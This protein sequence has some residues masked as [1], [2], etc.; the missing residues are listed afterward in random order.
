MSRPPSGSSFHQP[1]YKLPTSTL[2]NP[3]PTDSPSTIRNHDRPQSSVAVAPGGERRRPKRRKL[4]FTSQLCQD[5]STHLLRPL[6]SDGSRNIEWERYQSTLRLKSKWER[7]YEKFKDA[8]LEDQDEIY[9]GRT[10]VRGDEIRIIKDRGTVRRLEGEIKFG[11]LL[12]GEDFDFSRLARDD[13]TPLTITSSSTSSSSPAHTS[14]PSSSTAKATG[15]AP[16][17]SD[18]QIPSLGSD[19]VT[20][21]GGD[22]DGGTQEGLDVDGDGKARASFWG[23][24]DSD[25]DEIGGWGET[26]LILPQFPQDGPR[27]LYRTTISSN[28]FDQDPQQEE[29][30]EEEEASS[31]EEEGFDPDLL[32]FLKAEAKRKE[33]CG[34]EDEEEDE[35]D[36]VVDFGDPFWGDD[37][38]LAPPSP[39]SITTTD[40]D[41]PSNSGGINQLNL[42]PLD[43]SLSDDEIDLISVSSE[44][45]DDELEHTT[46]E[47]RENVE[48]LLRSKDPFTLP[49]DD[50]RGLARLLGFASIR[51]PP[52]NR[53]PRPPLGLALTPS[54]SATPSSQDP[55][56]L[57][58][59]DR[60]IASSK[61]PKFSLGG[62]RLLNPTSSIPTPPPTSSNSEASDS[63]CARKKGMQKVDSKH[64]AQPPPLKA[65]LESKSFKSQDS[66]P[67]VLIEVQGKDH[68]HL[69]PPKTPTSKSLFQLPS[70]KG[71]KGK[72][73]EVSG[74]SPS[75]AA[76]NAA[77]PADSSSSNE[78]SKVVEVTVTTEKGRK[79][80]LSQ[81]SSSDPNKRKGGVTKEEGKKAS[82]LTVVDGPLSVRR[83]RHAKG[84]G[85]S[86]EKRDD[87]EDRLDGTARDR[88]LVEEVVDD[89]ELDL[90][91]IED[92]QK[93]AENLG[94][95]GDGRTRDASSNVFKGPEEVSKISELAGASKERAKVGI[96]PSPSSSKPSS[97]PLKSTPTSGIQPSVSHT[98]PPSEVK[99]DSAKKWNRKIP[100][101]LSRN[102][103][104]SKVAFSP[105]KNQDG[106]EEEEEEEEDF[107]QLSVFFSKSFGY[108]LSTPIK[109]EEGSG[110]EGGEGGETSLEGS[111]GKKGKGCGGDKSVCEKSF[112]MLCGGAS[113][114]SKYGFDKLKVWE[115]Q[116]QEGG[117]SRSRR[118]KKGNVDL[119]E[120]KVER[121][122]GGGAV[123]LES[124][125]VGEGEGHHD[126]PRGG[127][128]LEMGQSD[129]LVGRLGG[130]G[131]PHMVE[132][133]GDIFGSRLIKT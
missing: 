126:L 46:E 37:G 92:S 7:I 103:N 15:L 62:P 91:L 17:R 3:A 24:V 94:Q 115:E 29:E 58:A 42:Q 54:R 16:S 69:P 118:K 31:S 72:V 114:P 119:V 111:V 95:E 35:D 6:N 124:R 100:S 101:S 2:S 9:L 108:G 38:H 131:G 99:R 43:Y 52:P 60:L 121:K 133:G 89:M 57:S 47:K 66:I 106:D 20:G 23:P 40:R 71:R 110:G 77:W 86:S 21:F 8:H 75:E 59:R 125:K 129:I 5:P 82:G 90:N 123:D 84:P 70:T 53:L 39:T 48:M 87:R 61:P 120:K 78:K 109:V 55:L 122:T 45:T 127:G 102:S 117:R 51:D 26:G 1:P 33:I 44:D 68:S 27:L 36:Q 22:T 104:R 96:T 10:D 73:V 32:E 64:L 93:V 116:E 132:G 49:Y 34:S 81:D 13:P 98:T 107:W 11:S 25:E 112:C 67:F 128:G 79:R 65:S 105:R 80:S 18:G 30:E 74:N 50:V 85:S 76:G 12:K 41:P 14:L 28:P 83:T 4:R 88:T 130:G 56:L 63:S 113:T 19:G 97:D